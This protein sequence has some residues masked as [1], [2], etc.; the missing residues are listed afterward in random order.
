MRW[1]QSNLFFNRSII[2]KNTTDRTLRARKK[3]PL[4]VISRAIS[5]LG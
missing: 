5:S 4:P 3:Q 1:Y 2:K